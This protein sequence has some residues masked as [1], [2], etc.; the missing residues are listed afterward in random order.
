MKKDIKLKVK[1]VASEKFFQHYYRDVTVDEI[2]KAAGISKRTFY[3]NFESKEEIVKII[4]TD[5]INRVKSYI[6]KILNDKKINSLD[7]IIKVF[8]IH[9]QNNSLKFYDNKLVFKLSMEV[10]EAYE[11]IKHHKDTFF[12]EMVN[13][14]I[15]AQKSGYFRKDLD[16]VCISRIGFLFSEMVHI[17]SFK[18]EDNYSKMEILNTF[19]KLFVQGMLSRKFIVKKYKGIESI[20]EDI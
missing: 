4:I 3:E 18:E 20:L 17:D 15:Q 2:V 16:I 14:F 9:S 10:P 19:N 7:K 13:L 6:N 5:E 8:N 11:I 12:K 1:K